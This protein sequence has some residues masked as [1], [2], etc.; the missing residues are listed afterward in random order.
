MSGSISVKGEAALTE[1]CFSEFAK[2][3]QR[4]M[5]PPNGDQNV[6]ELL[7]GWIKVPRSKDSDYFDPGRVSRII[8]RQGEVPQPI[9]DECST[10]KI[11]EEAVE[12]FQSN[13]MQ[14]INYSLRDDMLLAMQKAV[15]NDCIMG[16]GKKRSLLE[17]YNQERYADFLGELL[18]YVINK[19]NKADGLTVDPD[20]SFLLAEANFKCPLCNCAL[21]KNVRNKAI[22]LYDIVS[23]YR[24]DIQGSKNE[25]ALII[26]PKD[27]EGLDNKIALCHDDAARY[28]SQPVIGDYLELRRRKDRLAKNYKLQLEIDGIKLEADIKDVVEGLLKLDVSEPLEELSLTSLTLDHKIAPRNNLLKNEVKYRVVSYYNYISDLFSQLEQSNNC[29]FDTIA[30]E[31][32]AA[33]KKLAKSKLSQDVVALRLAEWINK[34]SGND[35]SHMIASHIIVAFFIQNCE[36]FGVSAQQSYLIPE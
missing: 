30:S 2:C 36:V 23:I 22:R 1:L 11:I 16:E 24:N 33:Y 34:Q 20:D 28:A 27:L 7:L 14:Y 13:I 8:N 9:R 6:V 4:A 12:Q 32:K 29:D 26:Q 18:I 25:L 19:P 31:V 15:E 17:A 35:D 10:E 21:M 3:F 5:Q